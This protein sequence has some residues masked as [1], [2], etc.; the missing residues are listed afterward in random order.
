MD[1]GD[2]F[3]RPGEGDRKKLKR[4]EAVNFKMKI[5]SLHK[6]EWVDICV[7]RCH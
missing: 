2:K 4:Q 5:V 3:H 1:P 6:G 7:E